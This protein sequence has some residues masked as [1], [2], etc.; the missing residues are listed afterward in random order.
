MSAVPEQYLSFDEYCALEE[1]S[2]V[3]HE[4]FE[5][6]AYAMTGGSP[7]HN[8]ITI[9]VTSSLR[10]QLRDKSCRIYSSD[11]RLYVKAT[12]LYTYA[13]AS[14]VCGPS[15][16]ADAP[17][18]TITN[19]TVIIEVLSPSTE[20]Y[21]RG[22]KFQQYRK[23]DSLRA[24]LLIAQDSM[25]VELYVRQEQNRWLLVE[26]SEKEAMVSLDVI[27]CTMAIRDIYED[28]DFE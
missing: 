17:R 10:P 23:I 2:G 21:D 12:G 14:V 19:P 9:N 25:H 6:A 4:F 11:Q 15:H 22:K 1:S 13:D 7:L 28:V 3:K 26:A 18:Y 16:F 5:G 8:L 20:S 24:Y 27:G